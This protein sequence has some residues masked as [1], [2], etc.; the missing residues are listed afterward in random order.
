[1]RVAPLRGALSRQQAAEFARLL[2]APDAELLGLTST[3]PEHEAGRYADDVR[4]ALGWLLQHGRGGEELEGGRAA[5][6]ARASSERTGSAAS[7]DAAAGVHQAPALFRWCGGSWQLEEGSRTGLEAGRAESLRREHTCACSRDGCACLKPGRVCNDGMVG[8]GGQLAPS[9]QGIP[10]NPLVCY[11][12]G[13]R[14]LAGNKAR[15]E[16]VPCQCTAG[17]HSLRARAPWQGVL[18]AAI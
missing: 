15:E 11:A 4:A 6:R 5:A 14:R 13:L 1:M 10:C 12:F 7:G 8:L 9:M 17:S 18:R 2:A 3:T 16:P